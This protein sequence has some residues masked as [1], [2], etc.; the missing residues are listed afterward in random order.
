MKIAKIFISNRTEEKAINLKK[1]FNNLNVV[2]WGD[3]PNFDM[4]INATSVG[5]EKG[6]QINLDLSK[7]GKD[8]L[9]YDIIYNPEETNFLKTGKEQDNT[10][11]NG[12][13]MFVYQALSAFLVWHGIKPEINNDV[14]KLLDI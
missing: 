1:M 11:S 4:I 9:F 8:K 7:V 14:I 13:L 2:N 10:I 3:V 5:L 6:D 12:K